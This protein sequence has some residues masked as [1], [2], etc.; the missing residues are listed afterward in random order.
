MDYA[1]EIDNDWAGVLERQVMIDQ[2]RWKCLRV[3]AFYL[4][5]DF[6]GTAGMV[7]E[8][9]TRA[10]VTGREPMAEILR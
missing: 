4:L 9:L 2:V 3:D 5:L 8:L 7:R 6:V 10:R 1:G